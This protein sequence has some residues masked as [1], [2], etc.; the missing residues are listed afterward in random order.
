MLK[1]IHEK[2]SFRWIQAL[3]KNV[4]AIP[5]NCDVVTIG[6]RESDIYELF[7]TADKLNSF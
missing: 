5:K 4:D 6:D 3:E 1:P 7:D 2:E